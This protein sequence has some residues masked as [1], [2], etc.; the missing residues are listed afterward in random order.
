MKNLKFIFVLLVVVISLGALTGCSKENSASSD[1]NSKFDTSSKISVISREE[2]S[3]TR[4]AFI[5]LFKVK[6][7]DKNGK[8]I[9]RTIETADISQSTGVV[10]N[11]VSS[12][13]NAI[14]YI[15]LGSINDNIKALKVNGVTPTKEN[16]KSG[17]YK[18]ARPF[19]IAT[20]GKQDKVVEDFIKF[21]LSDDGQKII[22]ENGYIAST[23][24]KGKFVGS[25]VKGKIVITGSSSVSPVMEKLKETYEKINQDV[26]I[27]LNQ[28]DST[29]GM[30]SVID[31]IAN[32]G[33]ASRELK[34]S[35]LK[36][37]L[38]KIVIAKD[39]IAII[40]N[41]NNTLTS[42]KSGDVKKIYIGEIVKWDEIGK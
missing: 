4:G 9:D 22:E 32:I 27:E 8:K 38:N 16:I 10:I 39:G 42:I 41:K 17:S 34:E 1:E 29:N 21:I 11:S 5:D 35:E 14:G 26:K 2:G 6:E 3:G 18:I 19:N 25:N 30:N 24:G 12:N 15:S 40:V 23:N 36:K 31:G 28:S 37:G 20:K 7:K 13:Q 33:M